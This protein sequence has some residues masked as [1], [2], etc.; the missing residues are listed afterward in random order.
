MA[1][2]RKYGEIQPGIKWGPFVLRLPG[3]HVGIS[4]PEVLQGGVLSLATGG[5]L[6]PL[7]MQ[8]FDI[9]FEVA[10][11]IVAIH[12]FWV[13]TQTFLFGDAYTAG[14]ITPSLPLTLVFLGNYAPGTEAVQAM[15]AITFIVCALFLFFGLTGLGAKFNSIIPVPLKAGI[16]MGAAIA[17]FQSELTRVQTLPITLIT[18]WIVVLTI[19]FSIPFKKL[20][21][22]KI[23][24][25]VTSNAI[26]AGFAFAAI[27]GLIS[28]ELTFDIEW[29]IFI[30]QYGEMLATIS[31][32]GVG[33]PTFSMFIA[34][35]PI[36]IMI[37]ILV[38]GDLLVAD[39]LLKGAD[40]ARPD[41]KI[42][43]N[44]TRTHF[45]L[46]FRNLG[47]LFTAGV[48]IPLHGP[49]WTG[50]QV[51]IIERYKSSKKA[52]DSIFTGTINWYWLAF[53]LAFLTPM[54]GIMA[55]LLPVALSLTLLLTGFAC[56]YVAMSMVTDNTSRGL[57]L[58]IG[59]LTA[60]Q[61]PIWGIGA[62]LLL[63]LILIGK[64]NQ[65]SESENQEQQQ[66]N[67]A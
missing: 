9:S 51:Y 35:I 23:K 37:Y 33:M 62:G 20:P 54:I 63:Y 26:L 58:A 39:T 50:V 27:A 1:K 64:S 15:I 22:S 24:L 16:I 6:A 40:K 7:M 42:D 17:A 18:A 10:W 41:E 46:V 43:V 61:G 55:P 44:H 65:P 38:F 28:G 45:A 56:A 36:S 34:A 13:W 59:M 30:P 19:M 52:L 8:Y 48:L 14:W 3:V 29:G 5:A 25:I 66:E 53:P 4:W 21:N 12:L 60:V 31:P 32:W 47:Q 67:S 57:A 11:S 2:K 49:I